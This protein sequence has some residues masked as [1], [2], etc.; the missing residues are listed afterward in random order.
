MNNS[1]HYISESA[2]LAP[3]SLVHIGERRSENIQISAIDYNETFHQEVTCK[4][5]EETFSF[6]NSESVSWVNINGLHD[7]D[8]IAKV[9]KNYGLHPLLLEDILNTKQRPKTEEYDNYL[10]LSLKMLGVSA[11]GKSITSEQVSLI[12]GDSWVISFQEEEGDV[13]D[14]LRKRLKENKGIIRKQGADYLLYRLI[15]TIVDNYFFVTE[16]FNESIESLEE[17]VLNSPSIEILQTI[18]RYKRD[19]VQLRKSVV[20]LRE[21]IAL[22]Q[23]DTKLFQDSTVR[24]LRDVYDHI[25]HINES[26]DAQRDLL[27]GLMELYH[28]GMSNKTNQV[29]QVLTIIATIFIPLTFIVG[30]YGMNFENM[31]ELKT[32][33]GYTIVWGIMIAIILVMT[34]IFKRKKWL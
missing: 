28:T 14:N 19:L 7:T 15:D 26:F 2:G 27:G 13:F 8:I 18:Q 11:D 17:V 29:M 12:L 22:L 32:K 10:Y 30:V 9:G 25:I 31:P 4:T 21:S 3:G 5:I 23:K 1:T 6:K 33:Y 24:Y 16:H 34:V 20:P